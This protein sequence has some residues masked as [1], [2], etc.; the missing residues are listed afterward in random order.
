[1]TTIGE[2]ADAA[3]AE[4]YGYTGT[5]E[6]TTYLT[7]GIDAD[8]LS[9]TVA[10]ATNFSRGLVQVGDEL[11]IVDA[12]D[13][14]T[15][16]LTLGTVQGR[17]VRGTAAVAHSVGDRVTMAPVIPRSSAVRAVQETIRSS[18]GLF[19]VGSTTVTPNT[20]IIG[21]DLPAEAV[22]VLNVS[23]L[24]PLG[25]AWVPVR[26]WT[27]DKFNQQIL[28]GGNVLPGCDVRVVY[29]TSPVVPANQSDDFTDSGLP[30]S[31]ADVIRL[32]AAWRLTSFLEP[33]TLLP[34]SAEADAMKRGVYPTQRIKVSQYYW[35]LYRARLDEEIAEMQTRYP[36]R[37]H[38]GV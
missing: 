14:D 4:V 10:S 7:V 38:Y 11:L 37:A 1:M 26:R 31:C 15:Q 9:I 24:P 21:Y 13:R 18:N 5:A 23:W 28:L 32:G 12:V 3:L 25:E 33:N 30:E 8:D 16:V 6:A 35:Q 36:I 2:L 22:G 20:F 19:A 34:H 17:G 29:M 27:H